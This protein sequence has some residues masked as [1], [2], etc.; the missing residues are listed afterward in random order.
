M[1]SIHR[2]RLRGP[3]EY[4]RGEDSGRVRFP[5]TW[6]EAFG[7]ARSPAQLRR[8]FGF[9]EGAESPETIW[10]SLE[11]V[12]STRVILN[13]DMIDEIDSGS[14][15]VDVTS[16]LRARNELVV[17]IKPPAEEERGEILLEAALLIESAG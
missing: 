3:W 10:L 16:R 14:S 11:L 4:S 2:I 6:R 12:S 13:G 15:R 5:T 17:I 1:S 9:P 7:D 8:S